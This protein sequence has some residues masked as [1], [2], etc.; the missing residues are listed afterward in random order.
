MKTCSQQDGNDENEIF[1]LTLEY[2]IAKL[3]NSFLF[4]S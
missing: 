4:F 2:F 3:Q 1:F